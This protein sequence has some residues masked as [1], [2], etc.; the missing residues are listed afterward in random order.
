MKEF[1]NNTQDLISNRNKTNTTGVIDNISKY[2]NTTN[3]L[4]F[5]ML[6]YTLTEQY[7]NRMVQSYFNIR[8]S[9]DNLE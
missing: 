7:P 1:Y 9:A 5:A 4:Y 8:Q 6:S 3:K 2:G